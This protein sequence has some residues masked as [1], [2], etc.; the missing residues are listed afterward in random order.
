VTA[1]AALLAVA[2]AVA[3]ASTGLAVASLEGDPGL[4]DTPLYRSYGEAIAHGEL[5]YRDFAVEYP[6]GALAPFALPALVSSGQRRYDAVFASA[7]VVAL[8]V[9]AAL[10]VLS[11]EALRAA[12]LR[13]ALAVGAFLA[14]TALLG[15]FVLTRFDLVAAA[16]TLAAVCAVLYRRRTLGP[17][18]LG[19]AIATKVY[20]VVLLPLLVSRTWRLEG[21]AG[22]LRGLAVTV[23]AAL[24]VYLPFAVVAPAGVA[25]S[26]WRQAARPLQIESLGA[27]ALLALHHAFG[28]P[29][30]WA[31][32]SGSQNLTGRVAAVAATATTVAALLA[33]AFLWVRFARGEAASA[34]RFVRYGAAAIAAV[35]AFGRVASPQFLIWLLAVVVLVPGR[36]GA[37]ATALVLAACGL[38][39]LW[40]PSAYWR[41]VTHFDPTASWLVL[42]R[43][44]VL[45]AVVCVLAVR[46]RAREPG[47]A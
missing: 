13:S 24:A 47:P 44:L 7:M 6:P 17:A 10:V 1:R 43:D 25:R 3:A 18:L 4:T 21:R 30:G 34:G 22:A 20:P 33:L 28:L 46:A 45:V 2:A 14:G 29:L 19:L 8:A 39:R 27:G 31:T 36:R 23:A 37:A 9:A 40:F 15:P 42:G 12:P 26:I 5:P 38:T 35:V 32:G 41:L 16:V 11:L